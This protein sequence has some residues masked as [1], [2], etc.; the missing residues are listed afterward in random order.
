MG[1]LCLVYLG[2]GD[3]PCEGLDVVLESYRKRAQIII[4]F[5]H[6][7]DVDFAQYPNISNDLKDALQNCSDDIDKATTG[8]E[9]IALIDRFDEGG[10]RLSQGIHRDGKDCRRDDSHVR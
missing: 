8:D 7:D 10:L 2:K 4:D 6:S 1:G 9:K 3:T 5:V